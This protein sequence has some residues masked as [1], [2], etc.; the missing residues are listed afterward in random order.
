MK[1]QTLMIF[2]FMIIIMLDTSYSLK[3]TSTITFESSNNSSFKTSLATSKYYKKFNSLRSNIFLNPKSNRYNIHLKRKSKY[4]RSN[5]SNNL[6][7]LKSLSNNLN[8]KY[9]KHKS[10]NN[11]VNKIE[12]YNEDNL[13]NEI[14]NINKIERNNKNAYAAY[15]NKYSD[16]YKTR[17]LKRN[18]V[19]KNYNINKKNRKGSKDSKDNKLTRIS[20]SIHVN[21]DKEINKKEEGKLNK[22]DTHLSKDSEANGLK[23]TNKSAFLLNIES[24][25]KVKED[26]INNHSVE[27]LSKIKDRFALKIKDEIDQLKTAL[28]KEIK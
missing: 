18:R 23:K 10:T 3:S 12:D 15:Y 4:S 5:R 24:Y 9:F 20:H 8:K 26:D 11:N 25:F 28:N 22:I 27:L 19:T 6:L 2:F 21:K 17:N 16:Y 14:F 1:S 13:I 7:K